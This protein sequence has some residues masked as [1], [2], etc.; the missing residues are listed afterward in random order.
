MRG[1]GLRKIIEH[2]VVTYT[3]LAHIILQ[4]DPKIQIKNN[5]ILDITHFRII[6]IF[7]LILPKYFYNVNNIV[8]EGNSKNS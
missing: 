8:L 4:N 1:G 5:K 2:G 7:M 6:I 3:F